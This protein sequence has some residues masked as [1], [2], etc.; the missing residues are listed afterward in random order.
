MT[1]QDWINL[2]R[3]IPESEWS[4]TVVVLS[5]GAEISIDA[6]VRYDANFLIVRGRVG[7]TVEESRGFMVPYTQLVY[8][9]LER[10]VKIEEMVDMFGEANTGITGV[11]PAKPKS[12]P[13]GAALPPT[14]IPGTINPNDPAAASRLLLEKMRANRAGILPKQPASTAN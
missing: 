2:F 14:P 11:N 3:N 12:T 6:F 13:T 7:G 8:T 4:K 1:N 10:T 9:R 5:N